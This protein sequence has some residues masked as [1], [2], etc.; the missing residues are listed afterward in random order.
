[1]HRSG[2]EKFKPSRKIDDILFC[3]FH[4]GVAEWADGDLLYG[5]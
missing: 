4:V 3:F 5:Q 1:M 2:V